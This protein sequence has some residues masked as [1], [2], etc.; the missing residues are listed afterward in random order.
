MKLTGAAA[1]RFISRPDPD[2]AGVLLFGGDPMRVAIKRQDLLARLLGPN[3]EDEMRLTR[4]PA[5]DIRK[6]GALLSD[7]VKATGFFPGLRAVLV[8]DATDIATKQIEPAL[9]DWQAG[10]ATIVVAAGQL[11]TRSSLRKLF[12]GHAGAVCI[13][14]YDDPPGQDEI[15]EMLRK[16]GIDDIAPQALRDLMTLSRELEPGDFRQTI[17]KLSLYSLSDQGPVTPGDVAAVAPMSPDAEI[18]DILTIVAEARSAEI[19]PMI[20]RLTAQG[21]QPVGLCIGATRHFKALY[22]AASDPGGISSGISRL[23]PPVYG[24]RRDRMMRQARSWGLRKLQSALELLIETDL[25]LRS[26]GQTAPAMAMVER[27]LIRLAKMGE[28]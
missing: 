4:L 7:A 8:E 23:R 26:A 20:Q 19:G 13:G 16:S 1:A 28:R 11:S 25:K 22:I 10:D 6:D 21:I 14:I 27:A 24:P 12:E 18:D 15:A 3:A 5:A 2:K 17:E 9:S